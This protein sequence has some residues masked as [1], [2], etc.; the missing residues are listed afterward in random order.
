MTLVTVTI[1]NIALWVLSIGGYVIWN[2]LKKNEKLEN[3]VNQQQMLIQ[4][5]SQTIEESNKYL[6]EIDKR[7]SFSSDDEIGWFFKGVK[8]IQSTLNQF[9]IK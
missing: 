2:L 5:I 3:M 1:L 6:K 4:E 9:I 7:G 8:E